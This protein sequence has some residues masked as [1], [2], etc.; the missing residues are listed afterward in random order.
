MFRFITIV[1]GLLSA[2]SF[3]NLLEYRFD[4][5][6]QGWRRGNLNP[7]TLVMTDI[8]AATWNFSGYI[9]GDDFASWAFHLS[10]T[11]SGNFSAATKIQFDYSSQAGDAVYPFV[12]LKAAGI[13]VL[14]Q[15]LQV[16]ADGAWHAYSYDFSPGTW[17]YFDGVSN[18][19]ATSGQIN[20]VL[21]SLERIGISADNSVGLEYTRLD[22]VALVPEPVSAFGLSSG[23]LL[24]LRSRRINRYSR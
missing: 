3:A 22:N 9:D 16:P 2:C 10:P 5:D 12:L 17:Q 13:Q 4:S 7:A 1:F 15:A 24:L 19:L 21:S 11:L 8:G 18:S 14:F 6:A 23:I 20:S